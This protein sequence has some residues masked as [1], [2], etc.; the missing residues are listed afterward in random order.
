T[1]V[2]GRWRFGDGGIAGRSIFALRLVS[3]ACAV[4]DAGGQ[5]S[6][7]A[8]GKPEAAGADEADKD[9]V[10]DVFGFRFVNQE[11]G[12]QRDELVLVL[13]IDF[14]QRIRVTTVEPPDQL[15]FIE[16]VPLLCLLNYLSIL[17]YS[18]NLARDFSIRNRRGEVG[19]RGVPNSI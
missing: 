3:I 5:K 12:G 17:T 4:R 15:N 6:A 11:R 9:I 7:K 1:L 10:H 18:N 19:G 13:F 2:F 14:A 8:A 16:H